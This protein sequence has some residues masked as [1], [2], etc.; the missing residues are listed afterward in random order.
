MIIG[1]S[2]CDTT[3]GLTRTKPALLLKSNEH[4][5]TTIATRIR[6]GLSLIDDNINSPIA[7]PTKANSDRIFNVI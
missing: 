3:P 6:P 1:V 7:R 2:I 5:A 4:P